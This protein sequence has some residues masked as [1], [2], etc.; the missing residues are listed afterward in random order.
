MRKFYHST[1][2]LAFFKILKDREI[3]VNYGNEIGC[4]FSDKLHLSN[5]FGNFTFVIKSSYDKF[6]T[7]DVNDGFFYRGKVSLDDIECVIIKSKKL[8]ELLKIWGGI[9]KV[10][11]KSKIKYLKNKVL[12]Y[13]L[14]LQL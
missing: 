13:N 1:N 12:V 7:D 4:Y 2:K 8:L 3:L 6:E 14:K 11:P 10:Y 5:M 9:K